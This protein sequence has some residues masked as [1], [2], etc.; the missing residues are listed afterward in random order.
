MNSSQE[1]ASIQFETL[2]RFY[3]HIA[4]KNIVF[5]KIT[6]NFNFDISDISLQYRLNVFKGHWWGWGNR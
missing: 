6:E 1:F 5:D 2:H 3:K 4:H